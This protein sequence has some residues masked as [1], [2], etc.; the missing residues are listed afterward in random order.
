MVSDDI[1]SSKRLRPCQFILFYLRVHVFHA[2]KRSEIPKLLRVQEQARSRNYSRD[3]SSRLAGRL[4]Y[5]FQELFPAFSVRYVYKLLQQ[6]ALGCFLWNFSPSPHTSLLN[7]RGG[8]IINFKDSNNDGWGDLAGITS[9]LDYVKEL[10]V[11]AIWVCPFYDSPQEDMGYDIANYEK[12]WPRYG[13][14]E[15]C[16]QMIEEAHKRGIKV[17]VDLVINHCSEE[18]EW[19]KE[20]R[21][22]KANPKRDWFFWRPPKG[23]DEKGNPIPPNNW[24]SF[25]GGSAWR[26]DEK[27]GEFFLHVFALG[28]PDFNWENEECRKAIYDS[29]VGYWLRHNVDGFRID[30][31]SMY[32][33]VE[34]LP[35]APITDP[36]VP[37]QKGTEFFIN[38]PR[39]HEY[40]KEMHNYILSQVPE[41]KEIMTVGEVGIGNED[42]FRVYTSAKEG[43]LNMMFNF[44]HTSVG[45]NQNANFKLA[46]A[47]SFLFIENTDCWSTIY[48]ENHDQP[49][50]VSR[51]GSDSPKWREISSKML[52]TLIISLTGTVFIYQGQ[53]LGMPNFKNRKIE[54][55]KCVEGTG[56]YAAIKRDYG[57][58]SEKMKKFFEALALISRDH[59]RTPFPWSADEPS[60]GFS[61]DAKPWID[62][63][64]SFRDG[65]N[66]ESELNDKDSVFFFWKKALQVRKEHKDILVYGHNFQFIDLDN[67]KL[68]MFTKDT[69]NKK[70]FAVFNF[71]SDNTDF[72]V[73]DNEA[74]YTMFFGNY[75]NSNG[76]SRTLQPW[77]G[78]LYLL[79]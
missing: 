53:E 60:A 69:D 14:N 36:T 27:T 17:I 30:V 59:G 68:F 15:D 71:S 29:S 70:M 41:G 49:R 55:I 21:S 50:S 40:H 66:A 32:S 75:A 8:D 9:K 63:N 23:Y 18:H 10:G 31:G 56:T 24:R 3:N 4:N 74:S 5:T 42:D 28:Q 52:A 44:K 6:D 11:D 33:K 2:K 48:L 22:S 26:Y 61:K 13:T 62:M 58:D 73:P 46:L 43:E 76:D 16:F 57:E 39:I 67:D 20:S 79:K 12:V 38:G 47:E 77:E 7:P 25:F 64:E 35:D 78:R 19:F 45:E 54:Q 72:S 37:Y 51:F 34:G 1:P 65:I